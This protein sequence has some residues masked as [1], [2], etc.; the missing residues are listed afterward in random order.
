[1]ADEKSGRLMSLDALRGF[2]MFFITG[3]SALITGLCVAFGCGDGWLATQM[4]HVPW[5]GFAHHD[6][7][8]PL[9]LFLAGVSWPFSLAS[10]VA[11]GRTAWQ[12]HRKVIVRALTLFLIELCLGRILKFDPHFRLMG[13]LA[14]IGLSWG[15]AAI[16]FMHVRRLPTRAVMVAAC[17]VGYW[18]LLR[19]GL[20]PDAPAGADSYAK[21]WNVVSWLDRTVWPNH[22]LAVGVYEPESFFSLTNGTMLAFLGMCAGAVLKSKE[23]A[24]ARKSLILAVGGVACLALVGLFT[25]VLGDQIVKALWTT[26]FVLAAAAYSSLMLALF[27]WIVD[28]KGWRRWTFYFRVIGMNSILVYLMMRLGILGTL[29]RF[30]AGGLAEQV[31]KPWGSVV[32]ALGTLVA[33]WLVLYLLY[34]KNAFLRV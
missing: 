7:I 3:G 11:K 24:A 2:D 10:Q 1:M 33:G 34:R 14:F 13:V 29:G 26:S 28:V 20:A 30:V 8:F 12:I 5:A 4:K 21:E 16:L 18:A 22:L 19:F 25:L 17:L 23:I 32:I 31:G 6:T 27:H 15:L 9:F